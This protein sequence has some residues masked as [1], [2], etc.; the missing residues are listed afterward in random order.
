[1]QRQVTPAVNYQ[2]GSVVIAI[3][4]LNGAKSPFECIDDSN[5]I[6]DYNE[7]LQPDEYPASISAPRSR[8]L[9]LLTS[10]LARLP[11]TS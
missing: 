5:C 1:V 11:S 8:L 9:V 2:I 4:M 10:T 6:I 3:K 7:I